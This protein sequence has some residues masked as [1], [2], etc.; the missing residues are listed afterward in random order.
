MANLLEEAS[1]LLTP[2]A[3]NN[4]SMLAVKPSEDLLGPELVANG[5]FST[6]SVWA[7][8]A[9]WS[10]A[11]GKATSTGGGRMFQSIPFLETNIGSKVVVSFDIVD[12]NKHFKFLHK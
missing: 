5:D 3:Y 6:D 2:T 7:K 9:N 11:N 4:G 1:I 8:D 10:I 12:Y